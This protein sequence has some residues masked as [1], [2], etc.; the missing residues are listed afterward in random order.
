VAYDA[1][2]ANPYSVVV[3][4]RPYNPWGFKAGSLWYDTNGDLLSLHCGEWLTGRGGELLLVD[5]HAIWIGTSSDR[6]SDVSPAGTGFDANGKTGVWASRNAM[7]FPGDFYNWEPQIHILSV[8]PSWEYYIRPRAKLRVAS[9][10]FKIWLHAYRSA[11]DND[12]YLVFSG[13]NI[14]GTTWTNVHVGGLLM[15]GTTIGWDANLF[16]DY[17]DVVYRTWVQQFGG[18]INI[19]QL[20]SDYEDTTGSPVNSGIAASREAPAMATLD[21]NK[22]VLVHAQAIYYDSG[23]ATSFDLERKL[24]LTTPM[25]SYT[26]SADVMPSNPVGTDFNVQSTAIIKLPGGLLLMADY[27]NFN[28]MALSFP[29]FDTFDGETVGFL[30]EWDLSLFNVPA[31]VSSFSGGMMALSG[32]I[33]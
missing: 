14:L 22:V 8:L 7:L 21:D 4:T 31:N 15:H 27:W 24:A 28:E 32:G 11:R 6:Y 1:T 2:L 16:Q 33:A 9:G 10:E 19:S 29:S 13:T 20:D 12:R 23:G 17:D 5:G 3:T 30:D 26:A 18:Q 25:G